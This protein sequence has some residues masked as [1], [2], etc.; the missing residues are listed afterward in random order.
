MINDHEGQFITREGVLQSYWWK[1]MDND[2]NEFLTKCDNC[3]KT[4][5]FKE[6]QKKKPYN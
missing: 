2:I 3:Q 5:K 6:K 4:K 1:E